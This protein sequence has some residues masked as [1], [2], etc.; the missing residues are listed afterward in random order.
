MGE[1]LEIPGRQSVRAPMQWSSERHGGFST[2][3]TRRRALRPVPGGE[4]GPQR[5]NAAAQRRD[6]GSLLNWMERL[7]RRRRECAELGWG[8]CTLLDTGRAAVLAHRSDWEGARSSPCTRSPTN[9]WSCGS[10]S[11]PGSTKRSTCSAASTVSRTSTGRWASR[12]TRMASAGTGCA[13]TGSAW[14]PEPGSAVQAALG[15]A[16]AGPAPVAS[17]ARAWC[18]ACSRSTSSPDRAAGCT[19]GRAR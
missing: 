12:S 1:N 13:A 2:A 3:R 16:R 7:I 14:R 8:R 5:V 17:R 6:D 15:L 18:S 4:A 9:G 10:S 11:S 19:G